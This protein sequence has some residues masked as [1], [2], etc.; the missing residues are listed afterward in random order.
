[1][2]YNL[3]VE[4]LWDYVLCT[5]TYQNLH[6]SW[7]GFFGVICYKCSRRGWKCD[8]TSCLS[9]TQP[10]LGA[11]KTQG[12]QFVTMA[13]GGGGDLPVLTKYWSAKLA[14]H[15]PTLPLSAWLSTYGPKQ[16]LLSCI[17]YPLFSAVL[18]V[19]GGDSTT[20]PSWT[21]YSMHVDLRLAK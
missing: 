17:L 12:K 1:M 20:P 13:T 7:Y 6:D 15:C 2:R 4:I 11:S 3:N 8:I 5:T 21:I 19:Q 18:Q 14:V 9:S 16:K 10:R